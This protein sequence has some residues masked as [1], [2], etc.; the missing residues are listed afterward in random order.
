MSDGA[1]RKLNEMRWAKSTDVFNY[2]S[3]EKMNIVFLV[4]SIEVRP[5]YTG[6]WIPVVVR[7]QYEAIY[8]KSDKDRKNLPPRFLGYREIRYMVKRGFEQTD[9]EDNIE[10]KTGFY[11]VWSD[12]RTLNPGEKRKLFDQSREFFLQRNDQ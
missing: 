10:N 9:A 6:M 8:D 11:V 3:Q 4:D 1:E 5:V 7:G 12:E 2:L